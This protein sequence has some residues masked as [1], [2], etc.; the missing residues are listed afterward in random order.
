[1]FLVNLQG[2]LTAQIGH[3]FLDMHKIASRY[4]K[5]S[6][7]TIISKNIIKNLIDFS[8]TQIRGL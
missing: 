4:E 7:H 8:R 6:V 3:H 1:M 5:N 2:N